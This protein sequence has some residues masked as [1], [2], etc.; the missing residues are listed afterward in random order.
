MEK[1]W[2]K[3]S[4]LFGIVHLYIHPHFIEEETG[5]ESVSNLTKVTELKVQKLRCGLRQSDD[6]GLFLEPGVIILHISEGCCV[7]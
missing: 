5:S 6:K 7:K 2:K 4:E 1:F 3:I